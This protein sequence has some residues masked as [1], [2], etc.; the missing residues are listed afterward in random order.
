MDPTNERPGPGRERGP[1]WIASRT[2][3]PRNNNRGKRTLQRLTFRL[4]T[5][6]DPLT[7]SGRMA[8]TLALLV[9]VGPSGFTS[10]EASPLG[11]ARRTSHYVMQLRELGVSILTTRERVGDAVIGRYCLTAPVYV[12]AEACE[13]AP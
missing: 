5:E 10:G 8:Q 11:W 12:V 7:V 13:T 1:S 2:T 3:K 6:G 4:T 9:K